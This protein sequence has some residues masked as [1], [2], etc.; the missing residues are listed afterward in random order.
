M[1]KRDG[2]PIEEAARRSLA[3]TWELAQTGKVLVLMSASRR[4]NEPQVNAAKNQALASDLRQLRFG[5]IPVTGGTWE[6]VRD[7]TT[8]G[9]TGEKRKVVEDTFLISVPDHMPNEQLHQAIVGL[10]RKYQQESAIIK[11]GDSDR[12]FLVYP[13]GHQVDLGVWTKD[14]MAEYFTQMKYGADAANRRFAFEYAD[15]HTM[16]TRMAMHYF[17]KH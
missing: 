8:G 4:E 14:K 12:A 6:N 9:E 17:E 10:V 5:Y 2:I 15:D 3:R 16:S 11:Y 7:P 1:A 13:D